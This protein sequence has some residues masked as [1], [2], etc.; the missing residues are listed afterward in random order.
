[1]AY[2]RAMAVPPV[3]I[4]ALAVAIFLALA[5]HASAQDDPAFVNHCM[6]S[7]QADCLFWY[8]AHPASTPW[9]GSLFHSAGV[10]GCFHRARGGYECYDEGR[11]FA[12]WSARRFGGGRR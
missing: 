1:M 4:F 9:S 12:R 2:A 7:H 5:G 11:A 10:A 8:R 6:A 3:I